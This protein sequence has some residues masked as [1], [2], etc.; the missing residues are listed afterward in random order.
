ME[1]TLQLDVTLCCTWQNL[2]HVSITV[3]EEKKI[4]K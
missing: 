4:L 3:V 1:V 2:T